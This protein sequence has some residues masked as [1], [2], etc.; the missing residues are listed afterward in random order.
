MDTKEKNII[1][2]CSDN[3]IINVRKLKEIEDYNVVIKVLKENPIT[4]EEYLLNL[5]KEGKHSELF[6]FAVDNDLN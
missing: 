4:L 1:K 6:A 2:Q 5:Y 3:G